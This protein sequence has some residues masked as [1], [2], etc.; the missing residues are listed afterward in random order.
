MSITEERA[1]SL[2]HQIDAAI[3]SRDYVRVDDDG[4][5]VL[6]GRFTLEQLRKIL[7]ILEAGLTPLPGD[8]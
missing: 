4:D 3:D 1:I 2:T 8:V 5:I 7:S 6:D